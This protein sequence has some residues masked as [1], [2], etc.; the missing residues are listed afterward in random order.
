MYTPLR[1]LLFSSQRISTPSM[2]SYSLP[3][4]HV[5]HAPMPFRH[6]LYLALFL[7]ITYFSEYLQLPLLN[8]LLHAPLF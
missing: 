6:L 2:Y 8:Y 5:P 1:L 3:L 4:L 7:S